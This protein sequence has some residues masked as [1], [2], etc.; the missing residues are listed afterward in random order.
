MQR[1]RPQRGFLSFGLIVSLL[2][3]A[4]IVF[5]ALRLLPPYISNYECE[6]AVQA[7]ALQATY[8]NMSEDDIM[9]SV[10]SKADGYG[11][12]L[13]PHQVKVHKAEGTVDITAH[14]AVPVDLMVSQVELHFEL[15]GRNQNITK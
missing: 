6:Q 13:E 3:L 15:L 8:T 7:L 14:Y 9:K 4:S 2:V 1:Q 5:L 12:E 10:I 11:I